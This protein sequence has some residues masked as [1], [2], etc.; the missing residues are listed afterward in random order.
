MKI[1]LYTKFV[2]TVIALALSGIA[3]Q[4][5]IKDAHAQQGRFSFTKSG[6]LMVVQCLANEPSCRQI[7]HDG[8]PRYYDQK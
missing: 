3:I 6:A 1:D 8:L 7:G 5:T 4:M 2:L